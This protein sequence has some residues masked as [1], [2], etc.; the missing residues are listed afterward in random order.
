MHFY[1]WLKQNCTCFLVLQENG[2]VSVIFNVGYGK[3]RLNETTT[4]YN[5][6]KYHAVSFIRTG[7][8]ATLRV[9]SNPFQES[10]FVPEQTYDGKST[11]DFV[12]WNFI[13]Q[14]FIFAKFLTFYLTCLLGVI[15]RIKHFA[16]LREICYCST[17]NK[18]LLSFFFI[19]SYN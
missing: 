14:F 7:F 4:L 17:A 19:T 16:V 3:Q 12:E 5:D 6:G 9:D 1:L 10:A 2:A 15:F 8:N 13:W 11:A 18:Y